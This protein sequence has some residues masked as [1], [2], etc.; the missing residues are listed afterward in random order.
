ME[1]SKEKSHLSDLQKIEFEST[2]TGSSTIDKIPGA[3]QKTKDVMQKKNILTIDN[4]VAE[5]NNDFQK[6]CT[7]TPSGINNHKIFD[8]LETYRSKGNQKQEQPILK[9]PLMNNWMKKSEK[10]VF[11]DN[12]NDKE[13][14][15]I[16]D[17][18]I[19]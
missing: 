19:Q 10:V 12:H 16:Q 17:C 9:I 7:L 4:L 14:D 15:K 18:N 8:A 5:L 6:L 2:T 1:F 3:G 13:I 11:N